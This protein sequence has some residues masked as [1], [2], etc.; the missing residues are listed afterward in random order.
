VADS[1]LPPPY[2]FCTH[3]LHTFTFT[4]L[5]LQTRHTSHTPFRQ[6][7]TLAHNTATFS[8]DLAR[9]VRESSMLVFHIFLFHF[10]LSFDQN[11]HRSSVL[12]LL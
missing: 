10:P 12:L 4:K 1:K 11:L 5:P 8:E 2:H 3:L 9:K 7:Y 6:P